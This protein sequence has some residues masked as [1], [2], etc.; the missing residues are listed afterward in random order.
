M[1]NYRKCVTCYFLKY[2][3]NDET[4]RR[5]TWYGAWDSVHALL[6]VCS[7]LCG[8]VV[9]L[10]KTKWQPPPNLLVPP[11]P[12][13]LSTLQLV[14]H[15]LHSPSLFPA[16]AAPKKA[17][18]AAA[19]EPVAPIE[20]PAAV[21][22]SLL[23]YWTAL[24]AAQVPSSLA[25][26]KAGTVET[27]AQ[28]ATEVA[29]PVVERAAAADVATGDDTP[30]WLTDIL[31]PYMTALR[32]GAATTKAAAQRQAG[33]LA[34]LARCLRFCPPPLL[35]HVTDEVYE[36][37]V[38]VREDVQASGVKAVFQIVRHAGIK[39][40]VA[41]MYALDTNFSE[42]AEDFVFSVAPLLKDPMILSDCVYVCRSHATLLHTRLLP[43]IVGDQLAALE[44]PKT[45][46]AVRVSL[47]E[48]LGRIYCYLP[49]SGR[50]WLVTAGWLPRLVR[51]CLSLVPR[52]ADELGIAAIVALSRLLLGT[53]A[54]AAAAATATP[55]ESEQP[56]GAVAVSALTVD[57][58]TALGGVY[59]DVLAESAFGSAHIGPARGGADHVEAEAAV[60]EDLLSQL[61]LCTVEMLKG[62]WATPHGRQYLTR[63]HVT[64][65][66][67]GQAGSA[68]T[69]LPFVDALRAVATAQVAAPVVFE[70]DALVHE[71]LAELLIEL[72]S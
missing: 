32:A 58:A 22:W 52:H 39:V 68:S 51:V 13:L 1:N 66:S 8:V 65:S 71:S 15:Q 40:L 29:T 49:P 43:K 17:A 10:F 48:S 11:A 25:V 54:A 44:A 59:L 45:P 57:D 7:P 38:Q 6:V 3:L 19:A 21:R 63:M 24:C 60:A 50:D 67:S 20:D 46:L 27:V 36:L 35:V 30:G 72:Q 28:M 31:A 5:K 69:R 2:S 61:Q 4:M 47:V 53:A 16:A 41:V 37:T 42:W 12:L 62:I 33:V 9:F 26:P 14:V 34:G 55:V 23:P 18:A 70:D 56:T 64:R